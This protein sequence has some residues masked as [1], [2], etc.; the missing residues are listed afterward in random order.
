MKYKSD[1][2]QLFELARRA[3]VAAPPAIRP[4]FASRV[5]RAYSSGVSGANS[6]N[7]ADSL[8]PA[9]RWA[10]LAFAALTILV[11][12]V[13]APGVSIA[14]FTH[15]AAYESHLLDIVLVREK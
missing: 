11:A 5:A 12:A 10:V 9:F 15:D 2:D 3:P 14:R 1:L 6:D 8:L 7:L 13:N 4:G